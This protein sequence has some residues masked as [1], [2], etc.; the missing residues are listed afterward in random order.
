[1]SDKILVEYQVNVAGLKAEMKEVESSFKEAEKV[2]TNS[3][4]NVG[5][6]FK[7]VEDK[8][9][10]LKSQLRELK[11]QLANATDP[12]DIERLAKAA[13]KLTDQ[14]EDA[15]DA[16]KV[17][18]SESKFEQVGNAL[19]SIGSK[20]RNLDFKG[21]ADQSKLLVSATKSI[22]F[23]EAL[24]GVKQLGST[25]LN[26]GKSLLLN[27]I[28]LIGAAIVGIIA[29]FDKLANSGGLIG[30][31]F[32]FIGDVV[33][34]VKDGFLSLTD[35]IGLTD[36][37]ANEAAENIQQ[38]YADL[39]EKIEKQYGRIIKIA[40]AS[41]KETVDIERKKVLELLILNQQQYANFRD[42]LVRQ[43][44]TLDELSDEELKKLKDLG[45]QKADLLAENEV[46]YRSK[47]E[48]DKK[49]QFDLEKIYNDK[50]IELQKTLRDLRVQ[51]LSDDYEKERQVIQNNFNDQAQKYQGQ[52]DII[53][54]L[55][56][57]KNNE[58]A[59]VNTKYGKVVIQNADKLIEILN[60]SVS[61]GADA[62][63]KVNLDKNIAIL[64][65]KKE[66][67][68]EE[69]ALEKQKQEQIKQIQSAAFQFAAD[70]ANSLAQIKQNNIQDEINDVN[71]RKDFEIAALDEQ[72]SKGIISREQ[73]DKK[74]EA[75]DKKARDKE[76]VLKI[77]AFEA[78][79]QAAIIST[80]INTATAIVAQ[81]ANPTPYVGFVLAALAAASGAAQLAVINSQP[82]PK[83]AKGGKV[84]GKLHSQG[85]T[86][87]EA[88]R[89]EWVIKRNESIKN[90]S[91]LDAINKGKGQKYIY[92]MYVAPALKEQL[93]K[94]QN[95][96]DNT[97]ASNI[98]QSM[99]LNSGQF[100]DVNILESLKMN[101]R[102]DKE[103]IKYLAQIISQNNNNP[104]SW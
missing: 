65:S 38:A 41:G 98:A 88:E 3:A 39:S 60:Q 21:A 35:A 1:M 36:T 42:N 46:L 15:S 40:K 83:F 63:L 73:Y 48:D 99:L 18:A 13:G 43:G 10:S 80:L 44:R 6:E 19:G 12:K 45:N 96:K 4:K 72:L 91:L 25:L 92:E 20:L 84:N 100:K 24:G 90:D 62:E 9:K 93:K 97:F 28:F 54:E 58:L 103:N 67:T 74:K 27:P 75:I 82:T 77:E 53:K 70:L 8:T 32:G 76:R 30:K 52:N 2:G 57:K 49:K 71:E 86:L 16:A 79:K 50:L 94:H 17:F 23:S 55:E 95:N 34:G 81:L 11:A 56:I 31:V 51:N 33:G 7:N 29:N 69:I 61:N 14:I 59:D 101:R 22:T 104:R 85:G 68:S 89:D 26:V 78:Q 87:I 5:S 37:A 102:A 66:L 47:L 64:N